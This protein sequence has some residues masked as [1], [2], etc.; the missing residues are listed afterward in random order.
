MNTVNRNRTHI[1][2]RSAFVNFLL[3]GTAFAAV[4]TGRAAA[5]T[6]GY[7][8]LGRLKTVSRAN[9]VTLTYHYDNNGN[10]TSVVTTT[11]AAPTATLSAS[12]LNLLIGNS[13]GLNY[14]TTGASSAS[15]NNGV[16]SVTPN[17]SGTTSVTPPLGA[18]VYTLTANGYG[19]PATSQVTINAYNAPT[20]S[21]SASPTKGPPGFNTNISWSTA[22]ATSVSLNGGGVAASGSVGATI[23]S[24]TSYTLV[25]ANPGG[26]N[27]YGVTVPVYSGS[28]SAVATTIIQGQS[29][30]LNWSSSNGD[31]FSI[32]GLGSRPA[33]GSEA[34]SPS[35]T[36]TYTFSVS[37]PGGTHTSSTTITVL[38]DFIQTIQVTGSG[39]I[40]LRT[41]AN[42]AGYS[43]AM[44]ATINFVVGNGVTIMGTGDGGTGLQ[45]GSWPGGYTISLTLTVAAG[46]KV[47]GGGGIGGE[48]AGGGDGGYGFSGGD[49]VSC[50]HPIQIV[51]ESGGEVRGGGGGGGGSAVRFRFGEAYGGGGGGG[52]VPNGYGG[53]GGIGDPGPGPGQDGT[54]GSI[55]VVGGGGFGGAGKGGN[56][57]NF[58]AAGSAGASGSPY[59]GGTG[60]AAGYAIR[61]NGHSVGV[62]NSGS[63]SGTIG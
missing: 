28:I 35:A 58:G 62:T 38:T 49:A 44:N 34:V 52:G 17:T 48:G 27:S 8:A 16:G 10:R 36:T 13:T 63:T 12:A 33:S 1:T 5:D 40:N 9:G 19:P 54:A 32:S 21:I 15:I 14:A 18:T 37:G 57:G 2:R 7:D 6:Y 30:M 4:G 20:G 50:S 55:S 43:G 41:L 29:T 60:G 59:Y 31:S 39:P 23:N 61:K 51:I 26:S 11:P 45:T 42:S 24:A 47:Y 56:G 3:G 25:S 53:P 22:N 46:G